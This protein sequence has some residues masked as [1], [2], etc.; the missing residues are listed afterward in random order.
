MLNKVNGINKKTR[1]KRSEE[2]V[3][4]LLFDGRS[5]GLGAGRPRES[6]LCK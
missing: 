2:L 1:D 3:D 4:T 5:E 6:N